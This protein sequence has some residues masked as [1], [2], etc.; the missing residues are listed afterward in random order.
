MSN[1]SGLRPVVADYL[2]DDL[3]AAP[4]YA[5]VGVIVAAA[6]SAGFRSSKIGTQSSYPTI[7]GPGFQVDFREHPILGTI[8]VYSRFQERM[9]HP[10]PKR[11][12][13]TKLAATMDYACG[14]IDIAMR[15]E[16]LYKS[17]LKNINVLDPDHLPLM[18]PSMTCNVPGGYQHS[19]DFLLNLDS[20]LEECVPALTLF[21][22]TT[23]EDVPSLFPTSAV[24]TKFP[25]TT[26]AL[27]GAYWSQ[28]RLGNF[29]GSRISQRSQS[30]DPIIPRWRRFVWFN[31][32][33]PSIK[34]PSD[35]NFERFREELKREFMA[36]ENALKKIADEKLA[37]LKA[38]FE[39]AQY[40]AE[41]EKGSEGWDE[42][43]VRAMNALKN[44]RKSRDKKR[45]KPQ[46]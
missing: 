22:G 4:A 37:P 46:S 40:W 10:K 32:A 27:N 19:P 25:L 44:A 2:P 26:I 45:T 21:L 23:P 12:D 3:P 28:V 42:E 39:K 15:M 6:T 36:E 29:Q 5:Q 17:T 18:R 7:I 11:Q 38:R 30:S 8:G 13:S 16:K 41:K 33:V 24:G 1:K 31:V 20:I 9:K 35:E 14:V 43:L 34:S